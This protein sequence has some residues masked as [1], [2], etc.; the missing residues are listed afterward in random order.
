MEAPFMQIFR[1]LYLFC[2]C[3]VVCVKL[4]HSLFK[5]SC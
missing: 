3:D 4:R 2:P 1:S 5:S